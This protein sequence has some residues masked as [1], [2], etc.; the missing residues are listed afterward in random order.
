[1]K[2]GTGYSVPKDERLKAAGTPVVDR[3][4]CPL[5]HMPLRDR[6]RLSWELCWPL[7]LIDAAVVLVIH[8]PLDARDETLDSIWA[9]VAFFVVSPWVVR[10]A[11]AR[12]YRGHKIGVLRAGAAVPSLTYQESLKVMWLLAWRTLILLL[13][14]VLIVSALLRVAGIGTRAFS[15]SDP[16]LN[17]LGLSFIDSLGGLVLTPILVP[18]MLRKRYRGFRLEMN[19]GQA[20]PPVRLNAGKPAPARRPDRRRPA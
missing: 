13:A 2:K 10:R 12:R 18:G 20:V 11:L 9:I 19:V 16:L 4:A 17:A 3:V 15:T 5:F 6:I 7:A 14:A 1:M 8:G